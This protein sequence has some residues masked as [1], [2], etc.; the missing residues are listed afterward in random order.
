MDEIAAEHN[1]A[2]C[3]VHYGPACLSPVCRL[4]VLYVFGHKTFDNDHCVETFQNL[5][6]CKNQKVVLM[7]D[8]VYAYKIG[9]YNYKIISFEE[10]ISNN[11][12]VVIK[13]KKYF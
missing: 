4:P 2:D 11:V 7:Y 13:Q 12:L 5:I 9:V 3:I 6:P 10:L 8:T 1:L